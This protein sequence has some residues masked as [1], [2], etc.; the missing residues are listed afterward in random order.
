MA[1]TG[2]PQFAYKIMKM[3]IILG[4]PYKYKR[5]FTL[6]VNPDLTFDDLP[7]EYR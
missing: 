2:N 4:V 5:V 1:K 7:K 3:I 6:P